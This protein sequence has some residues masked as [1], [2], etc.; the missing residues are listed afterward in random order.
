MFNINFVLI[1]SEFFGSWWIISFSGDIERHF[2]YAV[3]LFGWVFHIQPVFPLIQY[4]Q[5][6]GS[7]RYMPFRILRYIPSLQATSYTY[8]LIVF[9]GVIDTLFTYIS[10]FGGIIVMG[11]FGLYNARSKFLL[12]VFSQKVKQNNNYAANTIVLQYRSYQILSLI[13]SSCSGS[14]IFLF[15]YWAGYTYLVFLVAKTIEDPKLEYILFISMIVW[16]YKM[17]V[18]AGGELLS[19]SELCCKLMNSSEK[20][21]VRKVA[22]SCKDLR[23]YVSGT[24]YF[25][26]S[27]F[28]VFIDSVINNTIAVLLAF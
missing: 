6:W 1:T 26:N 28:L 7:V 11:C 23:F 4:I 8:L 3:L 21:L 15:V 22:K 2:R 18:K 25:E 24:F 16:A 20:Q 9:S 5:S 13:A 19:E 27:T 17:L 10:L 12:G 14:Y